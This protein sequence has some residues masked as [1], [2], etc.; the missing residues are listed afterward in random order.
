MTCC[1]GEQALQRSMC[2]AP[3]DAAAAAFVSPSKTDPFTAFAAPARTASLAEG[4]RRSP[5]AR[6]SRLGLPPDG[7]PLYRLHAQ[8]LI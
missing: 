6:P 4:I 7:P 1:A 2:A 3:E 8:L 5:A